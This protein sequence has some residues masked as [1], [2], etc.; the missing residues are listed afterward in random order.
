M[1][2]TMF[3]LPLDLVPVVQAGCTDALVPGERKRFVTMVEDA[4]ITRDGKRWLKKVE[5]ATLAAVEELREATASEL[6]KLVPDLRR[7]I[8]VGEGKKWGGTIGVS[9]RVLFL[10]ATEQRIVRGR[11]KGSWTS[12]QYRWAPMDAWLVDGVPQ[13]PAAEARAELGRRWLAAFGPATT[14]D[15]KWWTGW[16]VAQTTAALAAVDAVEVE[17]EDGPGWLLPDDLAPVRAPQAVGRTASRT[18]PHHDGLE[19]TQLVPRRSW[20]R[21][22]STAT[23]TPDPRC[24]STV[25]PSAP[26]RNAA[27]ARS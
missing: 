26:G 17:L 23:A 12:S 3:V 15:V 5:T 9:T 22:S 21:R 18:R 8:T 25:G 10:L 24:G 6:S 16:T 14:T 1:R 19:G 7:Q 4:G 27:T 2:R 11:P 20:R 13:I